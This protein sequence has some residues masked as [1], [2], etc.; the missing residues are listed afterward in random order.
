MQE[1]YIIGIDTGGTYTDAVIIE[2]L[3]H[4]VVAA[5]KVITTKGDLVVGVLE[6]IRLALS[7]LPISVS[8]DKVALVS[9]STTLATNA[10]VEGHGS[11]VGVLLLGFDDAMADR[12]GIAKAFPS[13]MVTTV[14]GG[15]NHAGEQQQALDVTAL[16]AAVDTMALRVEAFA[17]A[18]KFA[19]RNPEH[20]LQARDFIVA[21]T[22]K[23]VTISTELS[24]SLDAPRRALTA[25]LNAQLVAQVSRLIQAVEHAMHTLGM[26]CPLMIVK[27]DGTLA[28]A[29]EVVKRPIET[30]LSGPAASLMGARWLS[31]ENNFVMTDMGGT[32]TDF[33]VLL[34]GRPKV[35][36]EGADI[37]GWRTMVKAV[38]VKTIGL[39]GD[40]EVTV[41]HNGAIQIGPKRVL[42]LSLLCSR[43]PEAIALLRSDMADADRY[44]SMHGQFVLLPFEAKAEGVP[45]D[46]TIG[47]KEAEL[48][49][50]VTAAP[51]ALRHLVDSVTTHRML[52]AL[53][54]KGLIQWAAVTPSDAAHVLGLQANWSVEGAHLG[55]QL[56][57]RLNDM[58]HPS[59]QRTH[60]FA[61]AIWSETVRLSSRLILECAAGCSMVGNPLAE[62]QCA[63]DSAFANVALNLS[64]N[65][66]VV[67]VGGPAAVYYPEVGRRLHCQVVFAPHHE[68]ASA[69]GAAT[70]NVARQTQVVVQGDGNGLFVLHSATGAERFTDVTTALTAAKQLA[71]TSA[72]QEVIALG[73]VTAT[74][75]SSITKKYMPSS[76][77]D[78]DLLEA[79]VVAYASGPPI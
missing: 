45:V 20:E 76:K 42:P 12:T 67:A 23:P 73:A 4:A 13:V 34:N 63:G 52:I 6:A 29:T 41:D 37:G 33:G 16:A 54:K 44:G 60:D 32:T 27:G 18:A 69:V 9:I 57:C 24:S 11:A 49:R 14:A 26:V 39:G 2:T 79:I 35:V 66:P 15:H 31:G 7:R 71:E 28:L 21:R 68:V 47:H 25:T 72:E 56:L 10:V 77:N 19:V 30:V 65:L 70:G 3:A 58:A 43:Y 51:Q 53:G 1:T 17:I 55:L 5:A 59:G 22:G 74:V 61:H 38:D 46:H 48:L 64:L 75:E 78:A 40:S 8:P 50:R 36:E 62:A